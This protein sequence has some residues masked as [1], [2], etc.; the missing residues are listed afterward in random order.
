MPDLISIL[1][2][3]LESNDIIPVITPQDLWKYLNKEQI[4]NECQYESNGNPRNDFITAASTTNCTSRDANP[5]AK[6]SH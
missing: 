5:T 3:L 1:V 2:S 4:T 6:D